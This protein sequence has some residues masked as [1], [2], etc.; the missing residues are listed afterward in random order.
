MGFFIIC[1]GNSCVDVKRSEPE[2]YL[3]I[4]PR[5]RLHELYIQLHEIWG[6]C[7]DEDESGIILRN[8]GMY[9]QVRMVLQR[10]RQTPTKTPLPHAS[11]WRVKNVLN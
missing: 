7:G 9:V 3:H 5:L 2:A 4:V 8:V 6:P 10:R 1:T 11:S